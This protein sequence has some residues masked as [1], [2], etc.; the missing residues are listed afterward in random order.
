MSNYAFYKVRTSR[1]YDR[2]E[3]A[4]ALQKAIRR[5]DARLAC[6]WAIEL[7]ESN[8]GPYMWRRLLVTSAEDVYGC[9]TQEVK[10]LYDAWD[11]CRKSRPNGGRVFIA[12]AVIL[13]CEAPKSRDADHAV[14]LVYDRKYKLTDEQLE[15]ELVEARASREEIPDY[16]YDV[17]T[18][19]GK[20]GGATKRKFMLDEHEDLRP[21]QAG[22]FDDDL[23]IVR[24]RTNEQY[25][26]EKIIKV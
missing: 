25:D 19:S 21:R 15:A 8:L 20:K 12:K 22:L 2:G 26:A 16:A 3:V 1:G 24:S 17:H 23:D 6:Y 14:C 11:L 4:S 5:G 13:L 7:F 9:V 18:R 10:A